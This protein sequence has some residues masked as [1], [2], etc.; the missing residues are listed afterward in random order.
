MQ[1]FYWLF[2]NKFPNYLIL[3]TQ[4]RQQ[5]CASGALL[6][7]NPIRTTRQRRAHGGQTHH[8][9][10][11]LRRCATSP[12]QRIFLV[13][14]CAGGTPLPPARHKKT[15][16]IPPPATIFLSYFFFLSL[17]KPLF[18]PDL[19]FFVALSTGLP[20]VDDDPPSPFLAS[21]SSQYLFCSASVPQTIFRPF[22]LPFS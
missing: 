19:T 4:Q 18:N 16:G 17:F 7:H 6:H 14:E 13:A 20:D 5:I 11:A 3:S 21:Y 12:H 15:G 9:A 1:I 10:H 22:A 2:T 8:A